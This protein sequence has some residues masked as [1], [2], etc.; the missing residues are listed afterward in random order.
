MSHSYG[1]AFEQ[2]FKE[3]FKK[4]SGNFIY[5]LPDQV[6]GYKSASANIADFIGYVYPDLFILEVKSI[7]GNTFPITNF[8]Q[9]EKMKQYVA[10]KGVKMG[11]VIWY[12]ERDAVI[13][14]PLKTIEKMKADGKKSVN[15]RT[16]D[17]DGYDYVKI[18]SVKKRVFMDSDYSVLLD[19]PEGW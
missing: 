12:H 15:I 16:I 5:R 18:P 9:Y 8:T 10:S 11:V 4:L 1:K 6:S 13:Y 14:V 17:T 7:A 3:D 2:K 19:L